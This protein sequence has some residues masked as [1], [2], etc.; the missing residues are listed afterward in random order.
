MQTATLSETG[1]YTVS[2]T[3]FSATTTGGAASMLTGGGPAS[4]CVQGTTLHAITLSTMSMGSMGQ[5][6]IDEDT[7]AMKQ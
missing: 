1:T 2:G 5:A 6:G 4:Y 7:I 3:T